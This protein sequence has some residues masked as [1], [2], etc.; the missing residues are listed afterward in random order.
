[1]SVLHC[2]CCCEHWRMSCCP[3]M[4]CQAA[5]QEQVLERWRSS[6]S[7]RCLAGALP[8]A[9][10]EPPCGTWAGRR[11]DRCAAKVT[12]WQIAKGTC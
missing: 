2:S 10:H 7:Q 9:V 1:M 8:A 12:V 4:R 6:R 11:R 3:C 5:G